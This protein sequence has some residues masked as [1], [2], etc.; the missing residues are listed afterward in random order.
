ML[1]RAPSRAELDAEHA[2]LGPLKK[3]V[4]DF[5]SDGTHFRPRSVP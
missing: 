1:G 2:L 4:Y 5:V 3:L